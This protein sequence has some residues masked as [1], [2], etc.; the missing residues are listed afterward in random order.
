[1]GSE[2]WRKLLH[3]PQ[4]VGWTLFSA[5]RD[6][7]AMVVEGEASGLATVRELGRGGILNGWAL[8]PWPLPLWLRPIW[9][10][11]GNICRLCRLS[12]GRESPWQPRRRP[13]RSPPLLLPLAGPIC[14]PAPAG[15]AWEPM[16]WPVS[17]PFTTA[18]PSALPCRARSGWG[19]SRP[20]CSFWVPGWLP[21]GLGVGGRPCCSRSAR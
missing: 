14:W 17:T 4:Q 12:S 1:M 21:R 20:G 6:Y 18:C 16:C 15:E 13:W 3:A 9:P 5:V 8:G 7:V 11:T 10:S 19:W 2:R